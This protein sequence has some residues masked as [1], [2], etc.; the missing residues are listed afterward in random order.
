MSSEQFNKSVQAEIRRLIAKAEREY[1]AEQR[2]RQMPGFFEWL[3]NKLST[4]ASANV[5][6]ESEHLPRKSTLS[7]KPF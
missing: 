2:E 7:G 4:G 5:I 6:D 3:S 1:E